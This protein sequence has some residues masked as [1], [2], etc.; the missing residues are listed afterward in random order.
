MALFRSR[1]V[2]HIAITK[3]PPRCS[4]Q[5]CSLT[6]MPSENFPPVNY[7]SHDIINSATWLGSSACRD[8]PVRILVSL[9]V[10]TLLHPGGD[11]D[12]SPRLR[13]CALACLIM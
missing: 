12:D 13:S 4:M 7:S 3:P 10:K 2:G 11:E 5:P 8:R 1:R 9:V 6:S